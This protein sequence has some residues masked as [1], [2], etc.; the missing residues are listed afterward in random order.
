MRMAPINGSRTNA[1]LALVCVVAARAWAEPDSHDRP[2]PA[3]VLS[4]QVWALQTLHDLDL[5]AGQL[6][7][8]RAAVPKPE[9]DPTP[10]TRSKVPAKYLATLGALRQALI[11]DEDSTEAKDQIDE[12]RDDLESIRED[13]KVELDDHVSITDASR[14]KVP[15]VM[16]SLRPSQL[17]GYL[18]AY[19]DEVP[20]PVQTL[21][22]AVDESR[23]ADDAKFSAL[24]EQTA[25]DIGILLA[26][27]DKEKSAAVADRVRHWLEH[28][29]GQSDADPKAAGP[30]LEKDAKAVV[31]EFDSFDVL[32]HWVERDV[33]EL[34]S[35]PQLGGMID[36]RIKHAGK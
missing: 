16:K 11:R 3:T 2:D 12:L 27:L 6:E 8:L 17:A 21:V 23:G 30:E 32:R 28:A 34:L 25:R 35:N 15:D 14:N 19:Q 4:Q 36:E 18:A 33:A 29:R 22:H 1:L 5:D 31:G 13:D 24:A 9:D 7:L 26:G 20:D 10:R